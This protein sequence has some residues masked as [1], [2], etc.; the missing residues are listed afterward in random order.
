[1]QRGKDREGKKKSR[2]HQSDKEKQSQKEKN[3]EAKKR[4]HKTQSDKKKE[5][6]KEKDRDNKEKKKQDNRN[7]S[8]QR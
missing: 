8:H 7:W 4:G 5:L 6:Y 2:Q 1:M 3:R